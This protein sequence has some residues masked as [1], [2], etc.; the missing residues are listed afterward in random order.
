MY[1]KNNFQKE[2]KIMLVTPKEL[3]NQ[4]IPRRATTKNR[5]K[6]MTESQRKKFKKEFLEEY[7]KEGA[8]LGNTS[9]KVG[10][11]RQVIYKWT[12]ADPDFAIE[13]E[14]LRFIKTNK[15]AEEWEEKH[16]YDEEYKKKFLELYTNDSYSIPSALTEIADNINKEDLN[17]WLKTDP[18]FKIEYKALLQKTRPRLAQATKIRKSIATAKVQEKQNEFLELFTE[19]YFNITNTC[20]AMGIQRSTVTT[21][22]RNDP[23]FKAAL[24]VVQDEKEDWVEDKLFKLIDE[25][26]MVA[27]IFASKIMLQQ[28]NFGRRHTYIE[29]PRHDKLT[30]EVH[31]KTLIDAVVKAAELSRGEYFEL[32]PQQKQITDQVI[33]AEFEEV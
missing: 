16:K 5:R 3:K 30:V 31:D 11:S 21:W 22:G 24:D 25:G 13:F 10:F 28:R 33:E 14:E 32:V 7:R 20:K 9:K 6:H 8:T 12:E 26:N 27:T 29:Q 18:D 15:T 1:G 19:N 2:V 23:D 17:Y 4:I